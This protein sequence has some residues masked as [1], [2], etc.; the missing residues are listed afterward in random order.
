MFDVEKLTLELIEKMDKELKKRAE[1]RAKM[2]AKF[3]VGDKVRIL[4]GRKIK[5]YTGGW[6]ISSMAKHIGES[7]TI[8]RVNKGWDDGRIS[9]SLNDIVCQWDERGL[10]AVKD[11]EKIVIT[12]DGKTTTARMF[13]GKKLIKSAEAK[14][15]PKDKFDFETGAKIAFDRLVDREEKVKPK[16]LLKNG[17]FGKTNEDKWFVFVDGMFVY[18]DGN[19]DIIEDINENLI[20]C[21]KG[22]I[23]PV[24]VL[25]KSNGFKNAKLNFKL[26]KDV[27]W[28]R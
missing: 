21:Y 13:E 14:C 2:K 9:Y 27:I 12:T 17:V 1:D 23:R 19:Y 6:V 3:N 28:R 8:K 16:D 24:N 18:E 10:E 4:D 7:H 11:E 20:F 25:V 15:N 5:N 22:S 26:N